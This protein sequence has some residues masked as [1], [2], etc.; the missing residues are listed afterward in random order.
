M[1]RRFLFLFFLFNIIL[2][3]FYLDTGPNANTVSRALPV[4][5]LSTAR[6]LAIDSFGE[7]TMDKSVIDGHFYSDKAPLP[8]FVTTG[9]YWALSSIGII[10]SSAQFDA[11]IKPVL[12][13][14]DILCGSIPFVIIIFLSIR[15][16]LLG[17]ASSSVAISAMLVFYGSFI[18]IYT[19]TF[20][21]HVFSGAL[22]LGAYIALKFHRNYF[23]SGLFAGAA[24][25]SE[26]TVGIVFL[27]WPLQV[28][29]KEHSPRNSLVFLLGVLPFALLLLLYDHLL[30][31]NAFDL[32]YN[33]EAHKDFA[34][35]DKV[36]GFSY[37]SGMAIVHLLFTPY[38]GIFFYMPML[39]IL[40][41]L[42]FKF[43][44]VLADKLLSRNFLLPLALL[45]VLIIS[46]HHMWWG[47]W[48]YGP[49]H[50]I[51]LA[52]LLGFET[53]RMLARYPVTYLV[54]APLGAIAIVI[55]WM[56]KVTMNYSIPTEV[57]NPFAEI[58]SSFSKGNFNGSNLASEHF[59]ISSAAAASLWLILF[60]VSIITLRMAYRPKISPGDR[61]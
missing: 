47:G 46:A 55:T 41:G 25:M 23:L 22:L 18:F 6:T 40:L 16:A 21:G 24:F 10:H 39:L 17:R 15:Y 3:C 13:L 32:A 52:I 38:R 60:L 5:S 11:A 36:L 2:T 43:K 59:G 44:R 54:I 58:F 57:N 19:G 7:H 26:Y 53:V 9:F 12:L 1:D 27:L 29:I 42:V 50:L 33:H 37:P 28:W 14:G 20:F 51:P 34:A 45:Y 35:V 56:A 48:C 31:G 49:R 8:T 4:L 30:T 61:K